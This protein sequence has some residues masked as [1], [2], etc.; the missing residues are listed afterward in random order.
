MPYG[1]TINLIQKSDL[2]TKAPHAQHLYISTFVLLPIFLSYSYTTYTTQSHFPLY[3]LKEQKKKT[4]HP[5]PLKRR[6][7]EFFINQ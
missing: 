6:Q 5:I 7:T 3:V 1:D 4:K 2:C